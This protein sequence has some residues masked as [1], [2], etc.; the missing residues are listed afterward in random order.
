VCVV[1]FFAFAPRAWAAPESHAT[2]EL[3]AAQAMPPQSGRPFSVGLL[4]HLEPGWHVYWQ[5]AGDSGQPPTIQWSL[6]PGFRAGAIAWPTPTRLGKGSVID[7]GYESQV[8]LIAPINP[9]A[10]R[11]SNQTD[12]VEIAADVKYLICREICVPAKAHATL[13]L[14]VSGDTAKQATQW[15]TLFEQTESQIPKRLPSDWKVVAR[16]NAGNFVLS[17]RTAAP[18]AHASFFPLDPNVVENSAPQNFAPSKTC[19]QLT[20]KKSDLLAKPITALR[21]VLVLDGGRAYEIA[22]PVI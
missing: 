3:I 1:F 6:P 9:P 4:F 11:K 22:A 17:V 14:P 2:I 5:N 13:S 8:L 10:S 7:Y 21:G 15:R 12:A 18:A 16:S 20:L 19:F